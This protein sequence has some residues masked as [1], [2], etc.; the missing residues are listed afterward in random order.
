M[1]YFRTQ[2][3]MGPKQEIMMSRRLARLD[4]TG[5]GCV[6]GVGIFWT[7]ESQNILYYVGT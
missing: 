2:F 7:L 6:R 5:V 4:R 1:D 3:V